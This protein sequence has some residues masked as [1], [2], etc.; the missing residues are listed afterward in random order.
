M[1]KHLETGGYVER[2]GKEVVWRVRKR[3][4]WP[5]QGLREGD[6]RVTSFPWMGPEDM[7]TGL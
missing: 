5:G 4:G 1:S 2:V 6:S 7:H 3:G